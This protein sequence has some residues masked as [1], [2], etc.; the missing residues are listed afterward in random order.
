MITRKDDDGLVIQAKLFQI[1]NQFADLVIDVGDEGTISAPDCLEIF[2]TPDIKD[3]G[4][5]KARI[6][7]AVENRLTLLIKISQV[8][9]TNRLVFVKVPIVLRWLEGIMR[10]V[11]RNAE[12]ERTFVF[13]PIQEV[14]R[15]NLDLLVI[16]QTIVPF[17]RPGR[18]HTVIDCIAPLG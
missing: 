17:A 4:P 5:V 2:L 14:S 9:Q 13:P 6:E 8:R 16:L 10:M 11:I 1:A 3:I 7:P 12:E 18:L 15:F